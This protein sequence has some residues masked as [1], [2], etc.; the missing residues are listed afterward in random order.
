[1]ALAPAGG[2]VPGLTTPLA[3]AVELEWRREVPTLFIVAD[4]DCVLPIASMH[5]LHART[6]DPKRMVV[7]ERSDHMHFCDRAAEVHEIF[8]VMPAPGP[9]AE[10]A[11]RARPFAELCPA[12]EAYDVVRSLALAHFDAVLKDDPAAHAFGAHEAPRRLDERGLRARVIASG[13]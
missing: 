4:E 10:A 11:R 3:A 8:R 1:V 9:L 7:I 5:E 6:P 12:E 13:A 2:D